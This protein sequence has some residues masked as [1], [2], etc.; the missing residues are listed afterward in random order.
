MYD[1]SITLPTKH[2]LI[3]SMIQSYDHYSKG[4]SK[5]DSWTTESSM[6]RHRERHRVESFPHSWQTLPYTD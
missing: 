3:R 4:G 6:K 1:P 2:Y 5:R